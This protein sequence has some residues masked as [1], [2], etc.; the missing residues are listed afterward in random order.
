MLVVVILFAA[1]SWSV[2]D[3][4]LN[5]PEHGSIIKLTVGL[6]LYGLVILLCNLSTLKLLLSVRA[7][8]IAKA[9]KN[10]KKKSTDK[11]I[12]NQGA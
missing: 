2:S 6:F 5:Q 12:T 7:R 9:K 1:A 8:Y 4:L 10:K 3:G 11:I